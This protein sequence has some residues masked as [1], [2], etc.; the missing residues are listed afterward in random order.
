MKKCPFCAEEI[1]IDAKKC[2]FCWEWFKENN[3]SKFNKTI[4][5][6]N[7]FDKI[8]RKGCEFLTLA[9]IKK[10]K[11][12]VS[13]YAWRR[14]FAK[15]ID[16]FISF[17]LFLLLL[18]IPLYVETNSNG[19]F[20]IVFLIFV[21]FFVWV[22]YEIIFLSIFWNTI[23]RK[24]LW[25]QVFDINLNKLDFWNTTKRTFLVFIFWLWL[26]LPLLSF[27]AWIYQFQ[28]LTKNGITWYDDN[29]YIIKY[30]VNISWFRK[31]LAFILVFLYFWIIWFINNL[32]EYTKDIAKNSSF[33]SIESD[34]TSKELF[35][36]KLKKETW[37]LNQ[38]VDDVTTLKNIKYDH[39][40]QVIDYT[41]II[42]E[43]KNEYD[44]DISKNKM[45]NS[46]LDTN[47]LDQEV[48]DFYALAVLYKIWFKHSYYDKYNQFMFSVDLN[49]NDL[50]YILSN[51]NKGQKNE[52]EN[53]NNSYLQWIINGNTNFR[54]LPGVNE[55]IIRILK[56]WEN[57]S[58]D[59]SN[60]V[61]VDW[62]T[63]VYVTDYNW[64]VWWAVID[65]IDKIN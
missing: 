49:E 36:E 37:D 14:Y 65:W 35:I 42:N 19:D 39:Q 23:W 52:E 54:S 12:D 6:N 18:S 3:V 44:L 10:F 28:N 41:Y 34:K 15:I 25:I 5:K 8:D 46:V 57:V 4:D 24:I 27:I 16:F 17:L 38:V 63:W 43:D 45:R 50:K 20:I 33:N 7:I 60:S 11:I 2:R 48:K 32:P 40:N 56:K 61:Y 13:W 47:V 59:N 1:K 55:S 58:Y 64:Y 53:L 22:F 51:D 30:R 21:Y 26:R 31:F 9:E 62:Y 29:R